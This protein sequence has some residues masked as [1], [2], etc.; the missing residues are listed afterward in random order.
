MHSYEPEEP[1]PGFKIEW[2]YPKRLVVYTLKNTRPEVVKA[3]FD[4]AVTI[5]QNWSPHLLYLTLHDVAYP[6]VGFTKEVQEGAP[7]LFRTVIN[8]KLN[9]RHALVVQPTLLEGN[10]SNIVSAFQRQKQVLVETFTDRD[11][12]MAWLLEKLK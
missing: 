12:A 1:V 5:A 6:D 9:G 2:P 7:R 8:R 4:A 10:A 11:V 3:Y